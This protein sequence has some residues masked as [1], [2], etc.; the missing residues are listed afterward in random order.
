MERYNNAILWPNL[1]CL[2]KVLVTAA[3]L[4]MWLANGAFQILAE[5]CFRPFS[6][7]S[8]IDD[9]YEK[10]GLN[11]NAL[12]ILIHP[13]GSGALALF[14]AGCIFHCVFAMIIKQRCKR[15]P[16]AAGAAPAPGADGP[17]PPGESKG[18]TSV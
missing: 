1:N 13:T 2:D 7:S 18:P 4:F 15:E 3:A 8:D 14:S 9:P 6:L 17:A 10:D 11:G 5:L 16:A 12:N